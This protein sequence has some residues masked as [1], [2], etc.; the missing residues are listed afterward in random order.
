MPNGTP[1]SATV[2]TASRLP[3]RA[4]QRR[5]AITVP[6]M[7]PVMMHSAYIRIGSGPMWNSVNG[8]LGIDSTGIHEE[9]SDEKG[10]D[11]KGSDEEAS[12]EEGMA[13]LTARPAPQRGTAAATTQR[14]RS[15]GHR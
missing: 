4:T 7:T 1:T 5:V 15:C 2:S 12:N 6:T 13:G 9:G 8:G 14:R 3:P 11:E 10:S